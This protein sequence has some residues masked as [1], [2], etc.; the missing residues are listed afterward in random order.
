MLP[1]LGTWLL[2]YRRG[3]AQQTQEPGQRLRRAR[4][5][6]RLRYR[7]IEEASQRIAN[8]RANHEF[9]I[10]LSRL[11]DIENKGTVPSVYRLYSLCA[12]YGLDFSTVLQWYG[13]DLEQL[14]I[15]SSRLAI[16]R[17]RLIEFRPPERTQVE[18][19]VE[20]E[21]GFDFRRTSYFTRNIQRWGK[22]PIVLAKCSG[23]APAAVRFHRYG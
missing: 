18:F 13:I 10:G 2:M 8:Q 7:D 3:K 16:E 12:I 11:A 21:E 9:L 5:R 20:M 14:A 23:P 4:E 6:L 1:Y 15:D 17:T 19:P 22:L